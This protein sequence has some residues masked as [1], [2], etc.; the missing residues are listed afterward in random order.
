MKSCKKIK[1]AFL[2]AFD[3]GDKRLSSGS[4]YYISQCL[5]K[6]CGDVYYLDALRPKKIT[7][8]WLLKNLFSWFALLFIIEKVKELFF[9]KLG[10]KYQW[11]RR[12]CFSKYYARQIQKKLVGK[13]YDLIFAEKAS[14]EIAFLKTDIPII[15]ESD[16]V[17]AAMVDYYP[18]FCHLAKST[19]EIG[20]LIEK[21]ALEKASFF[22]CTSEWA[23][24]SAHKFYG[25]REEKIRVIPRPEVLDHVP[26]RETALRE[27]RTDICELLFVGV[28]WE[29]KGGDIAVDVVNQLNKLGVKSRLTICGIE[30]LPLGLEGNEYIINIGFLNRNNEQ[31]EKKYEELFFNAHFLILP[32]RAECMGIVFVQACAY[33]VPVLSTNTG[34]ISAVIKTDVNGILL[35]LGKTGCD[36]AQVIKDLWGNKERYNKMKMNARK[37]FEDSFNAERWGEEVN[38]VIEIV[39]KKV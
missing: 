22:V 32:T 30:N 1:I 10:K 27:K 39:L 26:S 15:Y 17:F 5:N 33:G 7:V 13:G 20:N 25:I 34:G 18:D 24:E 19:I 38:Q 2:T 35:D 16:T 21:K 4:I 6:N 8:P 12:L 3:A 11:D 37:I 14:I 9:R 28:D 36:Y 31:E 29:R 23:A